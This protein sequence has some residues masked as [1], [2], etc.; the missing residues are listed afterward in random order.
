VSQGSDELIRVIW[1]MVEATEALECALA[2]NADLLR[3]SAKRLQE[4]VDVGEMLRS[5]PGTPGRTNA[6]QAEEV[7]AEKRYRLRSL[8]IAECMA[9]GMSAREVGTNLGISRQLVSRYAKA[10]RELKK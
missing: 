6:K 2:T 3:Q 5:A 1:D 10:S 9:G 8:L 4:G 7:L